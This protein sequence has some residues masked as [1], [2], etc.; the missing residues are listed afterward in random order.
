[1]SAMSEQ[2]FWLRRPQQ[3]FWVEV[4]PQQYMQAERAGGFTAQVPGTPATA[5]FTGPDGMQGTTLMPDDQLINR[6]DPGHWYYGRDG[7]AITL[8][9]WGRSREDQAVTLVA[10]DESGDGRIKTV[11]LG[12]V[13]PSIYDARL[14]GTALIEPRGVSQ[15]QVYD[16]EHDAIQGHLEHLAA[17]AAG[18]H[19]ARCQDGKDHH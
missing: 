2:R 14:F 3:G 12:F 4:S 8:E 16:S 7:R 6:F 11:W 15:L 10:Q 1:M 17:R 9:E 5:A 13:C 18:H 19:C